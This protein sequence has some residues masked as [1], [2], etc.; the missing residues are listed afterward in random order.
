M[1]ISD[2]TRAA[3]LKERFAIKARIAET[4][5][6]I[7]ELQ[8]KIAEDRGVLEWIAKVFSGDAAQQEAPELPKMKVTLRVK[9]RDVVKAA[10]A[11]KDGEPMTIQEVVDE[12]LRQ[13]YVRDDDAKTPLKTK[14]GNELFKLA[15][16]GLIT[17]DGRGNYCAL[18]E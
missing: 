12:V 10:V 1:K 4:E 17:K 16:A 13:G 6:T 2:E 7:E 3:L 18:P 15:S 14:V 8:E 9:F 5:A 11:S